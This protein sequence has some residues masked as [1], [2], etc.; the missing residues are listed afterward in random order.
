MS[1][2]SLAIRKY[3]VCREKTSYKSLSVHSIA[4]SSDGSLLAA[5]FGNALCI[6]ISETLRN[7]AVLSAPSGQDGSTNKLIVSNATGNAKQTKK[8]QELT[9]KR[10]EII[11]SFLEND[12]DQ[13]IAELLKEK[14]SRKQE[15]SANAHT[16][17]GMDKRK[18][19]H[20]ILALN[21]LNFYQKLELFQKM[22]IHIDI[23]ADLQP[24]FAV[25][26]NHNMCAAQKE[27][28]LWNRCKMLDSNTRFTGLWM[29]HNYLTRRDEAAVKD[30]HLK[31]VTFVKDNIRTR[32]SNGVEA[33]DIENG[34]VRPATVNPVRKVAKIK[35]VVF[36]TGD[37]RTLVIV[38]TDSHVLIWNLLT[39][40]LQSSWKL[41][42]RFITV[43]PCTGLVAVCT[44]YDECRTTEQYSL[45]HSIF[46]FQ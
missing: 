42:V 34:H 36:G 32:M 13:L 45:I 31:N 5:G 12:D 2:I 28:R 10:D 44:I 40:R 19:F 39:L 7:V 25:Y 24:D 3:W 26:L 23:P 1:H 16:T 17:D 8:Q 35:H 15:T 20:K 29:L 30:L 6:Y 41:T 21:E 14:K 33:M 11:W 4:F 22:G 9:R 37:A 38:G 18:I 46:S 27:N 43:D